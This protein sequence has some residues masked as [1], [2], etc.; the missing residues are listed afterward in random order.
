[1]DQDGRT[2]IALHK[3]K[4]KTRQLFKL[5][6]AIESLEANVTPVKGC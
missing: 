4:I 6:S 1:M 3:R 5:E 2:A